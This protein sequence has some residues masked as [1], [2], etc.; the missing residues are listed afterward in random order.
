MNDEFDVI[1]IGAG[2]A[3]LCCAAELVLRGV[4]PLL[5][6]ETREVGW[7]LRSRW[8]GNNR[9]VCQHPV[10]T[11]EAGDASWYSLV[12]RLNIPVQ[13]HPL[14]FPI[15]ITIDGSGRFTDVVFCPSG[16]ALT[17]LFSEAFAG[18]DLP[19]AEM[20]PQFEKIARAG[21]A[22]PHQ[23]LLA[24]HDIP[25]AQWLEDQ[26]AD[27]ALAAVI[28]SLA[29][30]IGEL[31]IGSGADMSVFGFWGIVRALVCGESPWLPV[32]PDSQEGLCM[33]L[34]D[35]I[36]RRGGAVWRG[37]QVAS[38]S[39]DDGKAGHVVLDDGTEV[40]A[41][42]VAIATGNNRIPAFLDPLP[43]ELEAPMAY[44]ARFSD[45]ADYCVYTLLGE[46]VVPAERNRFTAVLN[47]S[48]MSR[49]FLQYSWPL[50]ATVPWCTE[51][52]K[53]F[54]ISQR[55]YPSR[56]DVDDEG[57]REGVIAKIHDTCEE[58]Y[59]GYHAATEQVGVMSHRHHWAFP[60]LA[61][62][63]LPRSIESVRDLW[64]VG[65]GSTPIAGV[66]FEAAASAG[67]LGARS[68]AQSLAR[69]L[70]LA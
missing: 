43:P 58:L 34:A 24:M 5:I 36:E 55:L 47:P 41:R 33:P 28:T 31:P 18:S 26:G 69:T 53:Q 32:V 57:G 11:P 15:E 9:G 66:Y 12:R 23:Q 42:A 21:M 29:S 45:T 1:V 44:N 10:F 3:G 27:D 37:H 59:P 67:I 19:I 7:T 40:H 22:I 14:H 56:Q 70:A 38:V 20:A 6:S 16:A 52:G 39:T 51:P 49:P 65:D 63:K 68:I 25:I 35:E 8:V 50:H 30:V 62:P 46:D 48:D 61:G 17:K 4:K 13:I 54:V 60:F 64:F 2:A